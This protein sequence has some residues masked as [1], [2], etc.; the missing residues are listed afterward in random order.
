MAN[1]SM[2]LLMSETSKKLRAESIIKPRC[3][4]RGASS[5]RQLLTTSR[6]PLEKPKLSSDL[7]SWDS[8]S[9]PYMAPYMVLALICTI[10]ASIT[11]WYDSSVSS[12]RLSLESATTTSTCRASPLEDSTPA[13]KVKFDMRSKAA[14]MVAEL[15]PADVNT[16]PETFTKGAS[17]PVAD[18]GF[19]HSL[20]RVS[21]FGSAVPSSEE[22]A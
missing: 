3:L 21:G 19:G 14:M 5:I 10:G 22:S 20:S 6:C 9:N 11:S 1:A 15:V 7:M 16:T 18:V 4:K 13:P 12:A 2:V 17:Q 8:V